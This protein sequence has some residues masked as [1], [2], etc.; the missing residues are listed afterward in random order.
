M[1]NTTNKRGFLLAKDR[2]SVTGR[3]IRVLDVFGEH[4][5]PCSETFFP[6]S[7]VNIQE[8]LVWIY[9]DNKKEKIGLAT[10][11]GEILIEPCFGKVESFANGLAKVNNGYWYDDEEYDKDDF[12]RWKVTK[13]L[14]Q[15]NWGVIDSYGEIV[16]PIEYESIQFEEDLTFIVSRKLGSHNVSGR[17]NKDGK[18]IIKDEKGDYILASKKY[19]WQEDFNVE[20][21][22][23]VYY[24]NEVGFVDANFHFVVYSQNEEEHKKNIPDEFE[25]GYYCTED[26]FISLKNGKRG[27]CTY[28]GLELIPPIYESLQFIGHNLYAIQESNGQF[29]IISQNG[30]IVNEQLFDKVYLFGDRNKEDYKYDEPRIIEN[31]L[32]AIVKKDDL[33]GAINSFGELVLP[34]K[35]KNLYCVN[36]HVFCGDNRD[37]DAT[38]RRVVANHAIPVLNEY[39]WAI[40]LDNGLILVLQNQLYGCIN[41]KG[42]IV[43]PVQYQELKYSNNM[44]VALQYDEKTMTH[45]RGVVNILNKDIIP[46]SNAYSDIE[47]RDNLILYCVNGK[48]GAYTIHGKLICQPEYREIKRI[49]D[50]L[51]KVGIAAVW[52]NEIYWGIIDIDGEVVLPICYESGFRIWDQPYDGLI[53]YTVSG[54]YIGYLDITGREILKPKYKSISKCDDG[55]A[56]VSKTSYYSFDDERTRYGVIDRSFKE[57]IPC[58][59]DSIEYIKESG[60]FKTN[61][62]YKTLDGR[63]VAEANGEKLLLDAKYKY[64]KSFQNGCAIAIQVSEPEMRYALINDDGEDI[65]APIFQD[66][67]RLDN[68]L[69]K[70]KQDDFYGLMD[71]KGNIIV[72]NK[73]HSIGSFEE[74]LAVTYIKIGVDEYGKNLYLYGCIDIHGNEI[75]TPDYEYMGKRSEGKIVI[76]KNN[77]WGLFDIRTLQLKL[78]LNIEYLG[79][80]KDGVCRFNM[81]GTFDKISLKTTGGTW[82]YM[83]C[84]GNVIIAAQYDGAMKFSEGIAAVKRDDKWGFINKEGNVVVSCEYDEVDSSFKDGI[85]KLVRNGEIFLFDKSGRLID[86]YEQEKNNYYSQSY[87]DYSIYDNPYYND[88]V[89]MD[90]QSIEF[91]NNL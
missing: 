40:L 59:F 1:N 8:G 10:I 25:W 37:I 78:I 54:N 5:Y 30:K 44:F 36:K 22:S 6:N 32:Y 16:I 61:V 72:Q 26:T 70:F 55:Y 87:D 15:G 74:N 82:G 47:I 3:S 28:D 75:L 91:W 77:V 80:Y 2:N 71:A 19:D 43:I 7:K 90:Q 11:Y 64:C 58:V 66:L 45:K 18:L 50:Y 34:I 27:L 12:P 76:M 53:G 69:Y 51:I 29:R 83:D 57:I 20:G 89:D 85:G 79:I 41:Q 60:L 68:G 88:N 65:H 81:G 9:E 56:I 73:Y 14:A 86:S 35:Y 63:Y 21:Y 17:L 62:G 24:K 38:G 39:D 23:K 52:G 4:M 84:N 49:T 42:D 67:E 48:W 31:A 33:F 13:R 46:L